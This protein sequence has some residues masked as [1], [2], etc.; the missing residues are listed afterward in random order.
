MGKR[1]IDCWT[2]EEK[3]EWLKDHFLYEFDM[4]NFCVD[5][6]LDY[7]QEDPKKGDILR[8]RKNIALDNFVIEVAQ[9]FRQDLT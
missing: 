2:N 5:C 9:T 6:L 3:K 4:L 8:L 7:C 1:K